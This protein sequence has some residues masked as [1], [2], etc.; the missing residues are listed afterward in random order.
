M[1]IHITGRHLRLTAALSR[2]VEEKLSRA[3]RYFDQI[4]WAQVILSVEKHRHVAEI[5]LHAAHQTFQAQSSG[6]DLYAAIDLAVDKM[7]M[8][9]RKLKEKS[10]DRH[11]HSARPL[12]AAWAPEEYPI[13]ITKQVPVTPITS[14]EA[15]KELDERGLQFWLF[16][17]KDTR[18][19]NV[20]Y[21]RLDDSFG[22]LEPLQNRS[23]KKWFKEVLQ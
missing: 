14:A 13:S 10:R 12:P 16:L 20:I 3:Q 17:N 8:Q 1:K 11:K 7:Q 6:L 19:L 5:T 4:I 23:R 2:Y 15:A 22:I 18:H 9:L 21:R